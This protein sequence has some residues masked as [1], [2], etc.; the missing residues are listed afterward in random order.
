MS[1]SLSG[2][3]I[4]ASDFAQSTKVFT[5][6]IFKGAI[7]NRPVTDRQLLHRY[8][9][10]EAR[11]ALVATPHQAAAD[12]LR[13]GVE[14]IVLKMPDLDDRLN[15]LRSLGLP[16]VR[17]GHSFILEAAAANG[18]AVE[19]RPTTQPHKRG[20]ASHVFLDHI[21]ILVNDLAPAAARWE[22]ILGAPPATIGPYPPGGAEA[23]RFLLGERMI[24]L[25]SPSR[26]GPS[27]LRTRLERVGEGP[28]ALALVARD[29]DYT[30]RAVEAAGARILRQPPHVLVHP[31]DAAGTLIQLT[32][33][34]EH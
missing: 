7:R 28:L 23:A 3:V 9:V 14:R 27:P 34:V 24:E 2:V 17:G 13:D 22:T 16:M 18:V 29:L 15:A 8:Y 20:A 10:D 4:R 21:A 33:R 31:R 26:S 12:G 1:S 32:P 5:A 25:V 6:L 19:L 30:V 11:V